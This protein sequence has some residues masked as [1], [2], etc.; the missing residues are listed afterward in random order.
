MVFGLRSTFGYYAIAIMA[1]P[2]VMIHWG[3]PVPEA[4]GALITAC[5]LGY[6]ALKHRAFWLGVALHFSVALTMDVLAMLHK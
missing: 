4:F 2:Y 1:T 6:L 5:V 3:K